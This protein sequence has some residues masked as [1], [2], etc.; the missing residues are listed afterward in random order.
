MEKNTSWY[1]QS[2]NHPK[3]YFNDVDDLLRFIYQK[4]MIPQ[5]CMFAPGACYIVRK[6]QVLLHDRV[7]Y[8]NLNKLMN[9]AVAP[10]FPSEAHQI[11]RIL[12]ILFTSCGKVNDWMENEQAFENKLPECSAYIQYKYDNRPRKFKKLRQM[13]G[14]IK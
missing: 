9:Y 12:P 6:E 3:K 5:Y 4:P 1:A 14:L 11:E 13:L 7:F 8:R 2:D 10:N